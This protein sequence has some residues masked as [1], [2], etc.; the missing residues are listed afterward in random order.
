MKVLYI[1]KRDCDVTVEKIIET[2]RLNNEVNIVHL[3]ENSAD[4]MLDLVE[5]HDKLIMW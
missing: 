4:T 2:Q 3:Y 1:I 5:T